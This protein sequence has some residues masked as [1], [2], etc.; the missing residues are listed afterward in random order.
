[1]RRLGPMPDRDGDEWICG[2]GGKKRQQSE[3]LDA[4]LPKEHRSLPSCGC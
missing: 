1:M 2:A 3:Y 4:Q